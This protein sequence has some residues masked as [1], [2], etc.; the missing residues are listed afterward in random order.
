MHASLGMIL[1]SQIFRELGQL[2]FIE[3]LSILSNPPLSL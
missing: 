2:Q 3:T 1:N